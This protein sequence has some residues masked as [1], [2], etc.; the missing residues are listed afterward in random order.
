MSTKRDYNGYIAAC[1]EYTRLCFQNPDYKKIPEVNMA[2]Y[3]MNVIK[4]PKYEPPF[5]NG[6]HIFSTCNRVRK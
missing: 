2:K 6:A 4:T 5:I 1:M 3:G